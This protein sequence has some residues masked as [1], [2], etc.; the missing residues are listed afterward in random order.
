MWMRC[1]KWLG[2]RPLMISKKLFPTIWIR[3]EIMLPVWKRFSTKWVGYGQQLPMSNSNNDPSG[4]ESRAE[5][6]NLRYVNDNEPGYMRKKWGRG[7][8]Y[9]D[10]RGN[11]VTDKELRQQF[12]TLVIPPAWEEVWICSSPNGHIQAT[13]RDEKGRK[14]Y[15]YHPRWE[16][17][18]DVDKFNKLKVFGQALPQLRS[19]V[20]KDLHN[21]KLFRDKVIALVIRLLDESLIRIGNNEYAQENGSF[22]LTTMQKEHVAV[23]GSKLT[24][25]FPGKSGKQQE[26]EVKNRRLAR[27]VKKCQELSGQTL[28]QYLGEDEAYHSI[29]STD[30][31]DYL[32]KVTEQNFTAK[33]FRTWGATVSVAAELAKLGPPD[34]EQA[35]Q[36]NINKAVEIAAKALGNT[37][38]VCR[39]YYLDPAIAEAYKSAALAK[40][41]E[42][43][44]AGKINT[45]EG[46]E[47]M[48][49]VVLNVLNDY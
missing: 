14:Q 37:P 44:E 8:T 48:E 21:R 31:N 12:E 18:R 17:M 38:A 25:T 41:V 6:A 34:S 11:R 43:V 30:V 40:A 5:S 13:G 2:Q 27:L 20:E 22:G 1:Q 49:S 28:F 39:E 7:F 32:R 9:F 33:D 46:L 3:L 45:I 26:V 29:T 36:E 24:F 16:E 4:L 19:Q 47:K 35:V 23:N 15:I 42:R 10:S